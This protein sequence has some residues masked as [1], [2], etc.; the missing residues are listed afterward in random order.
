MDA[1]FTELSLLRTLV[2]KATKEFLF[3]LKGLNTTGGDIYLPGSLTEMREILHRLT[4]GS[5]AHNIPTPPSQPAA[6][7]LFGVVDAFKELELTLILANDA[8]RDDVLLVATKS[9]EL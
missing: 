2:D 3:T 9:E 6:N 7:K 8:T 1:V 5:T 4:Y